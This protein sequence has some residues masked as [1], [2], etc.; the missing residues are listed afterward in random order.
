MI[1]EENGATAE[2]NEDVADVRESEEGVVTNWVT[3]TDGNVIPSEVRLFPGSGDGIYE[4]EYSSEM[5]GLS[6]GTDFDTQYLVIESVSLRFVTA[7]F[8][9]VHCSLFLI[10]LLLPCSSPLAKST[11]TVGD[12]LVSV[13]GRDVMYEELED[14]IDFIHMIK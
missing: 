8:L 2:M 9:S 5:V 1:M 6:I 10:C 12:V 11:V 4:I 14:V 13:N 7:N 3:S